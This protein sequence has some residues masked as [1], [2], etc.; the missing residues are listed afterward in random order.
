MSHR[1]LVAVMSVACCGSYSSGQGLSPATPAK[2]Y[3]RLN[4]Q[5]I[6][7]ELVP[8]CS[9]GISPAGQGFSLST[10]SSTI[11]V[12]SNCPWTATSNASW[13]SIVSGASGTGNGTVTYSVAANAGAQARSGT[14]TVAGRT[15]TVTQ[16]G[17][18]G[19]GPVALRYVPITPCRLVDTRL[20]NGPFGGPV[21]TGGVSRDFVVSNGSCGV[22]S[23]AQAFSLNFAVVPRASFAHLTAWPAGEPQTLTSTLSSD[24][25]VKGNAAIVGAGTGGA[26][27]VMPSD[28]THLVIDVTG[29]FQPSTGNTFFPVTPCR[30]ADTRNASGPLGGPYLAGNSTRAFPI[31]SSAC[32]VPSNAVAYSL[33]ITALP[34]VPLQ[35]LTA[36][37]TGQT[38]PPTATLNAPTGTST[39][40]AGIVS[41]GVSGQVSIFVT[42]DTDLVIDINGYFAPPGTGALSLYMLQEPCRVL[43]S[44]N[45]PG[46]P[47]LNGTLTI[48]LTGGACGLPA[49]ARAYVLGATAVPTG[50]LGYLTLWPN[51][52]AQPLYATLV[53]NDGATTSNMA[54]TATIN[55]S[56]NAFASNPT[57]LVLDAF[58]Y[59]GP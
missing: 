24:G 16:A 23:T 9:Y 17:N 7:I 42:N 22:P 6:A 4:G 28:D 5:V 19:S 30:V 57:Y 38:Q 56:I 34:R 35:N 26:I 48:A 15:F 20:A 33:N 50:G 14:L 55:G 45:P 41:A 53:A 13:I 46:S 51:G 39:S 8:T 21:L 2:E 10:G 31:L 32:G 52:Q 54:I 29:Y 58:G 44:R 36:W 1:I 12:S 3:I 25:R 43:D 11:T 47:A 59:F 27:S 37:A 18:P 40:N 49:S